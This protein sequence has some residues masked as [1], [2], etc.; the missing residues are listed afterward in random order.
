MHIFVSAR[1]NTGSVEVLRTVIDLECIHCII[2]FYCQA[3]LAWLLILHMHV[4][5]WC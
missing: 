5:L 2:M 1:E 4:R 3:I